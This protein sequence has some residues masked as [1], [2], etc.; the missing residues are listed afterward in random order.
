MNAV[1]D[2]LGIGVRS[3]AIAQVL[4]LRTQRLVILDD[5]VMHDR[6]RAARNVRVRICRGRYA[7]SRPAGMG[8][9]DRSMHRLEVQRVLQDFD[10]AD[11]AQ[12]AQFS[13]SRT[14]IPAESYPRYSRRRNPSIRIGTALRSAT[15][16]TMPHINCRLRRKKGWLVCPRV[17]ANEALPRRSCCLNNIVCQIVLVSIQY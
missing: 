2:D 17:P 13:G 5:A 16:P 1:R 4:E 10:L 6:D 9:T 12:A 7:V 8:D 11:R 14:A 15:T 3:E